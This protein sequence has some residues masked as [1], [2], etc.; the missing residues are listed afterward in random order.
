MWWL[1][2]SSFSNSFAFGAKP[3]G[4][5]AFAAV[6]SSTAA[7]IAAACPSGDDC[8]SASAFRRSSSSFTPVSIVRS[9]VGV[10]GGTTHSADDAS[11]AA[12]AAASRQSAGGATPRAKA[13]RLAAATT[14]CMWSGSAASKASGLGSRFGGDQNGTPVC[15]FMSG[16]QLCS[17]CLIRD[18]KYDSNLRRAQ[19][20]HPSQLAERYEGEIR[21][22]TPPLIP[23]SVF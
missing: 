13:R 2:S 10:N 4:S 18:A 16:G 8:A 3:P 23:H 9:A 14:N 17:S 12:T 11:S 21:S 20:T 7:A 5:D 15:V 22:R 6:S 19:P 1:V